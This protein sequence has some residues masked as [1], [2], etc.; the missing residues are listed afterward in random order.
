MEKSVDSVHEAVDHR[1]ISPPW[2]SG[3]CHARELTGAL[4]LAATVLE[5][6]G[7]GKGEGKEGPVSSMAGS[8]WVGRRWRGISPTASCSVMAV[9]AVEFRSGGNKR[10]RT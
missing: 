3:H 8:P 1:A 5:S 7:Q 2:T 6:S 4:P 10:G 9:T